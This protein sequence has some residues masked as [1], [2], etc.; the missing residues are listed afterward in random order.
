[1]HGES[2]Y[3]NAWRAWSFLPQA[4]RYLNAELDKVKPRYTVLFGGSITGHTNGV[5]MNDPNQPELDA[6]VR[7]MH[8][9][10][11]ADMAMMHSSRLGAPIDDVAV[12]QV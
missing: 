12:A 6:G 5:D 9:P 4:S 2:A 10:L 3:S 11:S 1:M 8:R 7:S